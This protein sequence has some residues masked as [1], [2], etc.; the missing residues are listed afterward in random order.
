MFG[1]RPQQLDLDVADPAADLQDRFSGPHVD[2]VDEPACDLVEAALAVAAREPAREPL[3]EDVR[4]AC[5]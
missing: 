5:P 1:T 4:F 2:G 3:V